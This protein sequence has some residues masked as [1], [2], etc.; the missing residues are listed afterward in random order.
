MCIKD[1]AEVGPTGMLAS[2][3]GGIG[4]Q[5]FPL[6]KG[7]LHNKDRREDKCDYLEWDASI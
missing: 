1:N 6:Y 2:E 3:L 5:D 4:I 7:V